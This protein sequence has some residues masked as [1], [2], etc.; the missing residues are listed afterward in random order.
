MD[1][2]ADVAIVYGVGGNP[3][4]KDKN[5]LSFEERVQSW[6]DR[7]YITH[8]MTG[9][10]W[11]G[12]EDY[13]TG[14]WDGKM[15]LDE[16]QVERHGDTIWHGHMVP[17]IVPSQNFIKYMKEKHIKRVIDVGID[18]IYLEEPEFWARAGYS[19]AFKREWKEYYGFDWRPQHES[20]ENTY[21]SNKLKYQLYYRALNECFTYAK[22]YGRSKGMNVRCYVPTHSLVNY[23]QWQIVSP[24]ASLASLPCVDGYIAQVWTGTSREP[25]YYNGVKKERVFENAFLEYGCMES[26]TAPTGRKVFFLTDPIEDRPRDWADYKKNYEATFTAKLLYPETADYDLQ[27][28]VTEYFKLFYHT[29]LTDEAYNALVANSVGAAEAKAAA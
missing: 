19:E 15:H 28:E 24:E 14:Q 23:A 10:A 16:G 6:R 18:A 13:F 17:Y 21:L 20:A 26:M 12:Y 8:F 7:G 5:A 9:I 25:N 2:R 29:D 22:E 11:G 3:S 4:D 27:A 1:N